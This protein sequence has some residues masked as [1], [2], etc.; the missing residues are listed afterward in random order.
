MCESSCPR[1]CFGV[2]P[3]LLR[4]SRPSCFGSRRSGGGATRC[5]GRGRA[6]PRRRCHRALLRRR[7]RLLR[8]SLPRRNQ[9]LP[10]PRRHRLFRPRRQ[11][12][13][14]PRRQRMFRPRPLIL[15]QSPP[16]TRLR[17]W[18]RPL[19]EWRRLP[20]G[21]KPPSRKAKAKAVARRAMPGMTEDASAKSSAPKNMCGP[22]EQCVPRVLR[23]G[24]WWRLRIPQGW[25]RRG[26]ASARGLLR[27]VRTMY[28][29]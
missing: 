25:V 23:G 24:G 4:P 12:L 21:W 22:A 20:A 29:C 8:W 7:S 1:S 26:A 17:E 28:H 5:S 19:R 27:P 16:K 13:F 14:R 18:R 11:W 15:P 2:R 3:Q 6:R 9:R 10:R